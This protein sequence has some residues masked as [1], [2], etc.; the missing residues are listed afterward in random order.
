VGLR[1]STTT[2]LGLSRQQQV[3]ILLSSC[4]MMRCS[5][6]DGTAKSNVKA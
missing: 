6:W 3:G 5:G 4:V 1:A 2:T